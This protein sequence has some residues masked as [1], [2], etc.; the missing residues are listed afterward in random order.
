M[1][2]AFLFPGQGSQKVGMGKDLYDS[3]PGAR[4]L[5]GEAD[6]IME[7]SLAELSFEGPDELL[8]QTQYTQPAIFV[9]SVALAELLM[10]KGTSPD[11]SAGHS[12]GEYSALTVAGVFSFA[13]ALTLVKLRGEAMSRAGKEEPGT[14]AAIMGLDESV[15][16]ELCQ[17]ASRGNEVVVPAN[18]NSPGQ[19]V[20]SGTISAV[21]EAM[22]FS[23]DAGAAKTIELKVSGA[24]HS[25]LMG[26]ARA[27]MIEALEQITLHHARFPVVMNVCAEPVSEPDEIK[28]NLIDQLDHPVRW[29][30]TIESLRALGIDDFVE[31]GPGRVLQGLNR[32]IDRRL[33]TRGVERFDQIEALALA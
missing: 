20:I 19:V 28:K 9:V 3:S 10:E 7:L 27:A 17:A 22:E 25:P 31:V 6:E 18:F 8:R 15:T 2:T 14:M 12:L 29:V 21:R 23:K 13:D 16:R 4:A 32:R 33:S 1:S 5:F 30:E 11:F 24:F 26:A